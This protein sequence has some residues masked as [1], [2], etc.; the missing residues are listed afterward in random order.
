MQVHAQ[1]HLLTGSV[2]HARACSCAGFRGL[3]CEAFAARAQTAIH[4]AAPQTFPM[5][6]AA[7]QLC[8]R[9]PG[10]S[11]SLSAAPLEQSL[12][13]ST[14]A[15]RLCFGA[16]SPRSPTA[17]AET[18]LAPSTLAASLLRSASTSDDIFG[19]NDVA[20]VVHPPVH[21]AAARSPTTAAAGSAGRSPCPWRVKRQRDCERIQAI[22]MLRLEGWLTAALEA[23]S[24]PSGEGAAD[25]VGGDGTRARALE[26]VAGSASR[27]PILPVAV[28]SPSSVVTTCRDHASSPGRIKPASPTEASLSPATTLI[29]SPATTL[30][31]TTPARSVSGALPRGGIIWCLS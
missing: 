30:A 22:G 5:C 13:P 31:V 26:V 15:R 9:A 20:A 6:S 2:S 21:S 19:V 27:T 16:D 23:L 28:A 10:P 1:K 11:T 3:L 12:R 24:P 25:S 4:L 14:A 8:R 17:R 18:A 7:R 29:A